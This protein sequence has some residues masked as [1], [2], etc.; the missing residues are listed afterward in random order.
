MQISPNNNCVHRVLV[1]KLPCPLVLEARLWEG[2][3]ISVPAKASRTQA[4]VIDKA[5]THMDSR[6]LIALNQRRHG[7]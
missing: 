2:V 1:L 3:F 4:M 7:G 6:S 5:G